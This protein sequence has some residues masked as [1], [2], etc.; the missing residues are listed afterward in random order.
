MET[1]LTDRPTPPPVPPPGDLDLLSI[2]AVRIL[3]M[4][5]VQKADSGHPGTPMALA[6]IA[7]LL[8]TRY[9]HHDPA[10]PAWPNRD[11]FVLS[12]GHA[13]MLQYAALYLSGY[14]LTLEDIKQFRQWGSKTPGH[15]E[16]GHTPGIE[17]TTGP[18]G[19]GVGNS[20]GMAVAEANLATVFNRPGHEIIDHRTYFICSDGDLMEGVSHEAASFAGHFRLGKLIGFYD[21][22]HITI[23]GSTDLTYSDNV[24]ERFSAYG[25]HVQ[26]VA[27]VN[28]L[29]ALGTAIEAAQ[30]E[31]ARPSLIIC[32]THIGYGSSKQDS[33]KSHGEAL[34][35]EVV[36]QARKTL[37]WPW[38]E[39]F[40]VPPEAIA[41]WRKALER[42]RADHEEWQMRYASYQSAYRD[43]AEELDRRWRRVLPP[44][45]DSAIPAF[46][47]ENGNVAT[48]ASSNV[49]L[50]AIAAKTPELL[51]GSA[52]LTPS[53]GTAL[54]GMRNFSVED[55]A[56]RY[57]HFGIRE[58]AMGAIMNG[59]AVHGGLIP[60]GGTFLIFSDYMRPPVRL[61]SLMRLH[62]IYIYT[63]DSIGLG[64]D[65]PTHQPIEQLTGLRSV[66]FMTV[67]RPA[68]ANEVAVAWRIAMA[69]WDGPVALVLTRQ[70]VPL[71]D[72][73]RFA[74]ADGVTRGAYVLGDAPGGAP[75][76]VLLASGSE[77][78]LIIE[79]QQR[80]AT[81]G[82]RA[83]VV[84]VPSLEIFARQPE[85]Y[86]RAVLPPGPPRVA[87][88]AAHPMSWYR[89]VGTTGAVLGLERFGASAPGPRV[90]KELGITADHVVELA[91]GVL[92]D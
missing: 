21:D 45:W 76:V 35:V 6:P 18:L 51:G 33:E 34:G 17:V 28:D 14:A 9:L 5:A 11:R 56:G 29:G 44:G 75:Q 43:A 62:V 49:V 84:S 50:N 12:A 53:N 92:K 57:F 4:D 40:F 79:A 13:C 31:M 77:V 16:Y 32:R 61:A 60:F 71:I 90:L 69:H 52:D 82:I 70:K 88:E 1:T 66:P 25:W 48:R 87:V 55:Y 26:H 8:Y 22:N 74:S 54:A 78:S 72:R 37:R 38:T 67:I 23:D 27:D 20:V 24:G 46:T 65:G 91:K 3:A 63:H 73:T 59:M 80:L 30:A 47:P 19:Q 64:E 39:A 2:N 86:Q 85:D 15:P 81:V 41:N 7:Y 83:R 58:H 89:W 42:G 68:D 36:A 10:D